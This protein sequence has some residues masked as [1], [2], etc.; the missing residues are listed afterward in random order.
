MRC[1]VC[2]N[3]LENNAKFCTNC[4]HKISFGFINKIKEQFTKPYTKTTVKFNPAL[5]NALY[6][7]DY[8]KT[9]HI[10]IDTSDI[11]WKNTYNVNVV[12]VL[13]SHNGISPQSII[14][15]LENKDKVI[16][17]WDKNNEYDKKAIEVK[18][19]QNQ[20]IGWLAKDERDKKALI[21]AFKNENEVVAWVSRIYDL[22]S[23]PGNLGVAVGFTIIEEQEVIAD[24]NTDNIRIDFPD[25]DENGKGALTIREADI[26]GVDRKYN[27]ISAQDI[28]SRLNIGDD[29]ILK[30]S[31][32]SYAVKVFSSDM[33]QFGFLPEW[34]DTR[35]PK[36]KQ[37]VYEKL[38]DGA[39]VLA[40]VLKKYKNKSGTIGI[41]ISI[42][43]YAVR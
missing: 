43:R 35:M 21:N 40:K 24:E 29:V 18:T 13:H 26:C 25:V 33:E 31:E 20:H 42:C 17:Y 19:T 30:N 23:Y 3:E 8:S 34:E 11:L 4:G 39:T 12:G 32:S 1:K 36:V 5:L 37:E 28:I 41:I 7:N 15:K 16:L 38:S 6:T 14:S 10:K 9:E 22:D 2:G 27:N